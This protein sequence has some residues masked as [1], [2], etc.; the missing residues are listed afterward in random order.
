MGRWS[1]LCFRASFPADLEI[2]SFAL[3]SLRRC[4]SFSKGP[5]YWYL[6]PLNVDTSPPC[7]AG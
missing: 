1:L 6:P 4:V 5:V 3:R 2:P 7:D